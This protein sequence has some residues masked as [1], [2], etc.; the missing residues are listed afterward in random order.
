MVYV[1][2]SFALIRYL[3][4]EPGFEIVADLL[5][6]ASFAR[7][8]LHLHAINW[9][10]VYYTIMRRSG[11]KGVNRFEAIMPKLPITLFEHSTLEHIKHVAT[12]KGKYSVSYADAFAIQ[13]ALD[14]KAHL[15]TG[16]PEI[17]TVAS[18]EPP[19]KLVWLGE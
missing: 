19:L 15:V 2:D 1:L 3:G 11:T 6:Q 17:K 4:K 8:E 9:G 5:N 12:I 13:L 7:K 16:D 10:E 18:K 14:L